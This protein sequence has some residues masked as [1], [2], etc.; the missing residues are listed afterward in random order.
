MLSIFTNPVEALSKANRNQSFARTIAVLIVSSVLFAIGGFAI[1]S[2]V[3]PA[4]ITFAYFAGLGMFFI[5][6]ILAIIMS[7]VVMLIAN[8]LGSRGR[9]F[10]S[11]TAVSYSLLPGSVGF[12]VMSLLV[13]IPIGL[14]VGVIISSVLVA[15]G[16]SIFFRALRE[17]F[18]LDYVA[19]LTLFIIIIIAFLVSFFSST[20]FLSIVNVMLQL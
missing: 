4:N 16:L 18:H 15:L 20:A 12:L 9:F 17:F 6:I 5:T 8:A 1:T 11:I 2:A 13:S 19:A 7:A 3:L 10:H 14:F